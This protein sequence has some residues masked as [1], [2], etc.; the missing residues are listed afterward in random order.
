MIEETLQNAINNNWPMLFIFTTVVVT[1]RL[2]YLSVHKHKFVLYKELF[3]L[4]FLIYA[5]LLFYVVTFQDVNYGTNNFVPFK[6]IFR[7]E[8][9]SKLFIK[10]IIGNILLFIPFGLFVSYIM[11][12]R[13]THPILIISTV[14]SLVIEY[15]QLKIGRTFDID[16]IILNVVGGFIG[17]L[18]YII[19]DVLSDYLPSFFKRD[20][21][22]NVLAIIIIILLFLVYTNYSLWGI[23]R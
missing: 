9:G 14:T 21:F 19:F 18:I 17:Y 20:L 4:A 6:E 13:K 3:M 5:M 10:N 22:K 15:T 16:D 1:I 23:L 2:V 8:F 7:Y 12:T 11:D